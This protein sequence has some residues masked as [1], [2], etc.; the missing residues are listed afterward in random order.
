[1]EWIIRRHLFLLLNSTRVL[2]SCATNL[3][4]DLQPFDV[5]NAF[6]HG[7]LEDEVY[8]EIPLGFAN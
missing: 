2:L 5:K 3:D 8:M 6:F 7:N 4:W 1:M